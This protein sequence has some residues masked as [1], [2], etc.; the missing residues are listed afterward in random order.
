MDSEKVL[1]QIKE[2]YQEILGDN[3]G[4]LIAGGSLPRGDYRSEWSDIDM[5][6]VLKDTGTESLRL[7]RKVEDMLSEELDTELD[8]MIVSQDLFKATRPE[9]L[10]D[11]VKNFLYWI[12]EE[13]L[14]IG[15]KQDIPLLS[16]EQY[17]KGT[18]IVC[19]EQSKKFLRRNADIKLDG[20]EA[21][22]I[23]LKKNVKVTRLI[24]RRG[25]ANEQF[26]PN[27]WKQVL[28][29][30]EQRKEKDDWEIW[31][32]DRLSKYFQWREDNAIATMEE[33]QLIEE[34]DSSLRYFERICAHI[35]SH[36]EFLL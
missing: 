20:V 24:L 21:L 31:E 9:D 2:R 29:A 26:A 22:R 15:G 19:V 8:T 27:T 25:L 16:F 17:K 32:Y 23:L 35:L 36:K 12:D 1:V 14:L 3:V 11:K 28:E 34:I 5:F 13:A 30:V 10:Q 18:E 4:V 33:E 6:A 7:V